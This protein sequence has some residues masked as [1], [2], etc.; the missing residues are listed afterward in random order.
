VQVSITISGSA[1]IFER[2]STVQEIG[3]VL[4]KDLWLA[5]GMAAHVASG[6]ERG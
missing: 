3:I 5:M 1:K 4:I 2:L 6:K